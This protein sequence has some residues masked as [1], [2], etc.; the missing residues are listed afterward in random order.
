MVKVTNVAAYRCS[1][2]HPHIGR[3]DEHGV[4]WLNGIVGRPCRREVIDALA[5]TVPFPH[6]Q[7][8][9][10]D[11]LPAGLRHPLTEADDA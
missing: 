6:P 4:W 9:D 11:V 7:E 2:G 8:W 5:K 1:R 3:R 10:E